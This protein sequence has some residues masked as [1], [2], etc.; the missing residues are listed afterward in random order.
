MKCKSWQSTEWSWTSHPGGFKKTHLSGMSRTTLGSFSKATALSLKSSLPCP[1]NVPGMYCNAITYGANTHSARHVKSWMASRNFTDVQLAK[2]QAHRTPSKS[3]QILCRMSLERAC[4][5]S[6]L[7]FLIFSSPAKTNYLQAF[8]NYQF[9]LSLK[10]RASSIPFSNASFSSVISEA[11]CWLYT[12]TSRVASTVEQNA[13]GL[14]PTNKLEAHFHRTISHLFL[15][16][17]EIA[18]WAKGQIPNSPFGNNWETFISNKHGR[19]TCQH[20]HW[21]NGT[22]IQAQGDPQLKLEVD[23]KCELVGCITVYYWCLR[24]KRS[25]LHRDLYVTFSFAT[26]HGFPPQ[27]KTHEYP[28]HH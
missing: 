15:V 25:Q 10:L 18:T 1:C 8:L 19:I 6:S 12:F 9:L 26:L 5:P 21:A 13:P 20:M 17:V 16:R 3:C 27:T 2:V 11:C 7:A 28:N 23:K 24:N 14:S 4:E 22:F